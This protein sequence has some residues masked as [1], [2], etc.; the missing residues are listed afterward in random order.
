M[1]GESDRIT[2][3]HLDIRDATSVSSFI[4]AVSEVGKVTDLVCVAGGAFGGDLD[5]LEHSDDRNIDDV[6]ELN[7]GAVLKLVR[8][9][10]PHL[11]GS[12]SDEATITLVSSIN[13]VRGYGL[14]V[15]S[16]AKAGLIGFT[17]AEAEPFGK[18]NIRI[19]AVLPGTVPTPKTLGEG[20]DFG[21]YRE[22]TSLGR[23]ATPEE[24]GVMIYCLVELMT[25][26]TGQAIIGD[27]GQEVKAGQP[28]ST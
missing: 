7:L 11:S 14:P 9:F 19:N 12:L 27:C 23:L 1:A 8:D 3:S 10:L 20:K 5:G 4:S 24:I 2:F 22:M 25:C 13:A 16:A 18:R 28:R 21:A 6:L 15:Y 26:V 17:R